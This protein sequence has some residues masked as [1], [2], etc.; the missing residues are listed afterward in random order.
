MDS[1]N[2][3]CSSNNTDIVKTILNYIYWLVKY[4]S[5][6]IK[7][8][9]NNS[10]YKSYKIIVE[11]T[12]NNL[13]M[14]YSNIINLKSNISLTKLNRIKGIIALLYPRIL[15]IIDSIHDNIQLKNIKNI[16]YTKIIEL[17]N[18]K[19]TIKYLQQLFK[20]T[21]YNSL[22]IK[23]SNYNI[24][25]NP[26]NA[27]LDQK[28]TMKEQY[29]EL[30][31]TILFI[32]NKIKTKDIED[33]EIIDNIKNHLRMFN[34]KYSLPVVLWQYLRHLYIFCN[35]QI[36]DNKIELLNFLIQELNSININANNLQY[37]FKPLRG[38]SKYYDDSKFLNIYPPDIMI[39]GANVL[40]I[41]SPLT[42]RVC[43]VYSLHG[44]LFEQNHN[45]D[46]AICEI[47]YSNITENHK[48]TMSESLCVLATAEIGHI[49]CYFAWYYS[50]KPTNTGSMTLEEIE[51]AIKIFK[52]N[53]KV[54][55]DF[56]FEQLY[57]LKLPDI[58]VNTYFSNL[59]T[60]IITSN[61]FKKL[62][63]SIDN[64]PDLNIEEEL[65]HQLELL[66]ENK[67]LE[68]DTELD[69]INS[70]NEAQR[71]K[72]NRVKTRAARDQ[73]EEEYQKL[74]QE[75]KRKNI[76]KNRR[77]HLALNRPDY[78][79]QIAELEKK[80]SQLLE[81]DTAKIYYNQL[82]ITLRN[83]IHQEN[84]TEAYKVYSRMRKLRSRRST[85]IPTEQE[86]MTDWNLRLVEEREVLQSRVDQVDQVKRLYQDRLEKIIKQLIVMENIITRESLLD[87]VEELEYDY[88][89]EQLHEKIRKQEE[90]YREGKLTKEQ[91]LEY[92]NKKTLISQQI[93]NQTILQRNATT[94]QEKNLAGEEIKRLRQ[95]FDNVISQQYNAQREV[96]RRAY[97]ER[98][99]I[100]DQLTTVIKERYNKRAEVKSKEIEKYDSLIGEYNKVF[101]EQKEAVTR[102]KVE[103]ILQQQQ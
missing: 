28:N 58:D 56:T 71:H 87:H 93:I 100:E 92:K 57:K 6:M 34:S 78:E 33:N 101:R 66:D 9:F 3:S 90:I 72:I 62:F 16:L 77:S 68:I 91:E 40:K 13:P 26:I 50:D 38:L 30:Y 37:L 102:A 36:S 73:Q 12:L 23:C 64:N 21:D 60:H 67:Q 10:P 39:G 82:M 97:L 79:Q 80:E 99:L 103:Q 85:R 4:L 75:E 27:I 48:L 29:N 86:I 19:P 55:E 42:S 15:T 41:T 35:T 43:D 18:N 83:Y 17:I 22:I 47:C 96:I 2:I 14:I 98:D 11:N 59:R 7:R 81:T 94:E 45:V 69:N 25:N 46:D 53:Y 70:L 49:H 61:N 51:N 24:I 89:I 31:N 8:E 63:E 88:I 32:I 65:T 20:I 52:R 5:I 84:I 44:L 1:I 54:P 76:Q 95:E 74:N